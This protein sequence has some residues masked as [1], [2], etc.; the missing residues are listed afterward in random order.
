MAATLRSLSKD[1]LYERAKHARIEGRSKM[2]KDELVEALEEASDGGGA[3]E[4]DGRPVDRPNTTSRSVWRGSISFGLITIPVGLFTAIEDRDVSF[5]LLSAQDGSRV[6][7]QRVSSET[8][9]E[10]DWD[11]IV[12][13]YEYEPDHYVVF[14]REE[15]ERIPAESLRSIEI[16]QFV[17]ADQIDPLYYDRSYY[18]APEPAAVKAYALF[19]RALEESDRL[20]VGKVTLR[21]KERPCVIRPHG[22]VLVMETMNWPDEIRIPVF[23]QLDRTPEVSG[24]ELE[25]A[26]LLIDQLTEDFDPAR[27][28]DTY[29]E[30]LEEAI[31]AKIE[32][33]EVTLAP[34]EAQPAQVTDLL[35]ALQA[36]VEASKQRRSA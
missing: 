10:V 12:K 8:G 2:D 30:R 26:H 18:V 14:T 11:D 27:F 22:G 25:M 23:E 29:R 20:G 19:S 9:D 36:S 13:G 5:H 24:K 31:E 7:Y 3:S 32:G 17:A 16:V 4:S 21:Q 34:E 33:N 1:E 6:R 28:R 15:L 35:E